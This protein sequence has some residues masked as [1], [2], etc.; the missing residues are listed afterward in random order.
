MLDSIIPIS[1]LNNKFKIIFNF[2]YKEFNFCLIFTKFCHDA[3]NNTNSTRVANYF[4]KSF[5]NFFINKLGMLLFKF[6]YD[7][8]NKMTTIDILLFIKY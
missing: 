8:F 1:I 5:C 6:I 7:F 3:F 4:E 2:G